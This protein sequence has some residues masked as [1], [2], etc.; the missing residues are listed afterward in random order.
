M[1]LISK[2][3]QTSTQH[4]IQHSNIWRQEETGDPGENLRERAWIGKPFAHTACSGNWTQNAVV[5]GK[6]INHY[7]TRSPLRA[8]YPM[9]T[10]SWVAHGFLTR[11]LRRLHRL[12]RGLHQTVHVIGLH[13]THHRLTKVS[14]RSIWWFTAPVVITCTGLFKRVYYI[15]AWPIIV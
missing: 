9:G 15:W 13:R 4:T 2:G 11:V 8:W 14:S 6:V 7:T 3:V 1:R 5:Q 10:S 12:W